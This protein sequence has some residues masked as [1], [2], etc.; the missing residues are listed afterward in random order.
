MRSQTDASLT[1]PRHLSVLPRTSS[2]SRGGLSGSR[3][4]C[5]SRVKARLNCRLQQRLEPG[6]K[7]RHSK[8]SACMRKGKATDRRA[9]ETAMKRSPAGVALLVLALL[10]RAS[11][12]GPGVHARALL[13]ATAKSAPAAAPL[14]APTPAASLPE[15]CPPVVLS[16]FEA[17]VVNAMNAVRSIYG[18]PLLVPDPVLMCAAQST[19]R[20]T[21]LEQACAPVSDTLGLANTTVAA[22]ILVCQTAAG[23]CTLGPI[24][25]A[26]TS[27]LTS[28]NSASAG[29]LARRWER[30]DP[31]WNTTGI[32][33]P[34]FTRVGVANNQAD[35]TIFWAA[36]LS[37]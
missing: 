18:R 14:P 2:S 1:D 35:P 24:D 13:Q 28:C 19:A 4:A 8:R 37:P 5:L 21:G 17:Q 22:R 23:Q 3:W 10:G 31:G 25:T 9:R 34:V 26:E 15:G 33:S 36:T 30:L 20:D 7:S 11:D 27:Q 16:K 32:A 12:L 29:V 6:H